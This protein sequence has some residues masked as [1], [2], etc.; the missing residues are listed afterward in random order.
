MQSGTTQAPVRWKVLARWVGVLAVFAVAVAV[1]VAFRFWMPLFPRELG[2]RITE[3]F[4]R[5]VLIGY[6]SALSLALPGVFLLGWVLLRA[7]QRR[8]SRPRAARW[9]LLCVS[10]LI[11][12][13]MLE[14]AAGAWLAWAHRMP[15]LPERFPDGSKDALSIVSL[16][17]S[18]ALGYPYDPHCSP[19]QIVG[20]ELQ[21]ALPSRKV[22]VDLRA[23]MG[24]SLETEHQG[25]AQLKQRPDLLIVCAGNNEF[26]SRFEGSRDVALDEAP[27]DP[28]LNQLYRIS[29]R[30]W[31]CRMVYETV[32]KYRL[33]G[34]P[35]QLKRHHPV[36]PPLCTPSEYEAVRS[37]FERRL[38]AIAAYCERHGIVPVLMIPPGNES[39]FEPTRSALPSASRGERAAANEAFRAARA[40]EW[41]DPVLSR[42]RYHELVEQYPAFAEAHFRLGRLLEQARDWDAA[43]HHYGL[44]RDHDG[45]PVR[46]TNPFQDVYREVAKRHDCILIDGP[47]VVRAVTPRRIVDDSV[48][49]DAHHPTLA[50]QVALAQAI[51]SALRA[52]KAFGWTEGDAPTLSRAKVAEE[53]GVDSEAWQAVCAKSSTFYRDFSHA[54]HDRTER[55]EKM[56]RFADAG[57]RI[58]DGTPPEKTGVP[59]IGVE[60]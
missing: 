58:A 40:V 15:A 57:R 41:S 18:S 37:D 38:D 39:G 32:S 60:R 28:A 55:L 20:A 54:R 24:A 12:V 50:G 46:C 17:G 35:A 56:G 34:P 1:L 5:T 51:L 9:L 44:A 48:I 13:A 42:Q 29:Q 52:R 33:G 16:G 31:L 14:A 19:A 30:S 25:L 36:D 53:F 49:H 22:A 2:R 11:G 43:R 27:L 6:A 8:E 10:F 7:R 59:G 23:K 26:L 4:L 45:F 47:E 3:V 21:R